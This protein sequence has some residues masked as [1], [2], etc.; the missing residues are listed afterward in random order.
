[1]RRS[2]VRFA[3]CRSTHLVD[4][5]FSR[6][7][8]TRWRQCHEHWGLQIAVQ[9]DRVFLNTSR[10][11]VKFQVHFAHPCELNA[12]RWRHVAIVV[13]VV[14]MSSRESCLILQ[15][16]VFRRHADSAEPL[17]FPT[18]LEL[19]D[20]V[21]A[22]SREPRRLGPGTVFLHPLNGAQW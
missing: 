10:L 19:L 2:P 17:M 18:S 21:S 1:M 9:V 3:P 6:T 11:F 14:E 16:P 15:C 12:G 13:V 4:K 8:E 7:V 5:S 20:F 22:R